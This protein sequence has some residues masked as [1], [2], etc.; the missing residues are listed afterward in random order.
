VT[1]GLEPGSFH[2]VAAALRA[3]ASDVGSLT[4]VLTATLGDAL[5]AGMVE[6][7]RDRSLGDRLAGRPGRPV[8]VRV[9]TDEHVL[10][11]RT[12]GRAPAAEVQHVVRGVVLSR[13]QVGLDEWVDVLA[14]EL[15]ALA[16]RDAAARQAVSRLLGID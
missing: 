15:T 8:A 16:R 3:D 7:E 2:S 11:L 13:R 1:G 4:R 12:A 9:R 5:P 10:E 6:V 14:Q